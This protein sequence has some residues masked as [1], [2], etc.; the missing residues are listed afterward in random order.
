MNLSRIFLALTLFLASIG[1]AQTSEEP[2][3]EIAEIVVT[4]IVCIDHHTIRIVWMQKSDQRY[5][6]SWFII[7]LYVGQKR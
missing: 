1:F 6:Q 5:Q 3:S 4:A 2:R 7:S